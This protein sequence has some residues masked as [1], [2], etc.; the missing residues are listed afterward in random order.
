MPASRLHRANATPERKTQKIKEG[1]GDESWNAKPNKKRHEDADAR[2]TK[3]GGETF[4]GLKNQAK[5][6]TKSKFIDKYAVTDA[7]VHDSRPLDD[8]LAEDDK[9]QDLHADSAYTGQDQEK[10]MSKYEVTN[11]AHE[12]GYRTNH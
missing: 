10:V 9:N 1:K 8:L 6:D 4:F 2:W 5:V 7:P 12:K 3:K 11:K